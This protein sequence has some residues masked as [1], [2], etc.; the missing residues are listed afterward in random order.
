MNISQFLALRENAFSYDNAHDK[1]TSFSNR[2]NCY[3]CNPASLQLVCKIALQCKNVI[4]IV[5]FLCN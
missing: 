4:Y 3:E 1:H 5:Y 2:M